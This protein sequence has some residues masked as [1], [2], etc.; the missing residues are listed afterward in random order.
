MS[1]DRSPRDV[2]SI[3]IGINGLMQAPCCRGSTVSSRV[4][5]FS[6]SGVQS[7]SRGLACSTE[8]GFTSAASRSSAARNRRSSRSASCWPWAQMSAITSSASSSA[9]SACSRISC[10]TSSSVISIPH[11][12]ATASSASSRATDCAASAWSCAISAVSGA[13]VAA[14]YASGVMPRR[15]SERTK[16]FRSSRVRVSTSGPAGSMFDAVDQHVDGGCAEG[17]VDLLVDL[18][19]QATFDVGTQLG[20]RVEL[21]R[22]ARELVVDLGQHLLADRLQRHVDRRRRVVRELIGD[23]LR[24]TGVRA[25]QRVLDLVDE[26]ARRR[27]RRPCPTAIR[28]MG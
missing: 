20:D 11:V 15:A 17:R 3:T 6:L 13:P 25:D 14:K 10:F 24:L 18:L 28:P 27:A 5:G 16:P 9:V 2:C 26:P 21:A 22:R 4:A 8:I 19:A 1:N 12:S 7:F 23:L